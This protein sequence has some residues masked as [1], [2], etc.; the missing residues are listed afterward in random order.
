MH[1]DNSAKA[2]IAGILPV[3]H[4]PSMIPVFAADNRKIMPNNFYY[5]D[6][7]E[8]LMVYN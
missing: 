2:A 7:K 3:T 1:P 6:L 8:L 5:F 4:W